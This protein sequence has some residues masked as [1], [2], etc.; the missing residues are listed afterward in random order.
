MMLAMTKTFQLTEELLGAEC[1]AGRC[2]AGSASRSDRA[3]K[4][5]TG[6]SKGR[7]HTTRNSFCNERMAGNL[8]PIHVKIVV[9]D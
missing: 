6:S 1:T 2:T 3:E 5:A 4:S 9:S 8:A 7:K